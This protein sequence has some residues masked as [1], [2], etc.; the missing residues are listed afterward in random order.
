MEQLDD[1]RSGFGYFQNAR[2]EERKPWRVGTGNE[3]GLT[4]E[5]ALEWL[6][7]KREEAEKEEGE[8]KCKK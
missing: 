6:A 5:E 2:R 8:E 4:R 3:K 1:C 7:R